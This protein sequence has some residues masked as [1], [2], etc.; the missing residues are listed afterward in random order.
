M[1]QALGK[2][3]GWAVVCNCSR[4]LSGVAGTGTG[5]PRCSL[6]WQLVATP[7]WELRQAVRAATWCL[8]R[9]AVPYTVPGSSQ[10]L[11]H[12]RTRWKL[13]GLSSSS[14]ETPAVALPTHSPGYQ[15]VRAQPESRGEEVDTTSAR[16]SIKEQ[17]HVETILNYIFTWSGGGWVEKEQILIKGRRWGRH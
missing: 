14:P 10:S 4:M 17:N 15:G 3:V 5:R 13:Q 11:H 2:G 8:S 1:G 7:S 16:K 12:R 9:V 6:T